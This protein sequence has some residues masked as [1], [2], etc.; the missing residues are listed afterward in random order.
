M[1]AQIKIFMLANEMFSSMF[2][3][4]WLI[5]CIFVIIQYNQ[6][7]KGKNQKVE[8]EKVMELTEKG[9]EAKLCPK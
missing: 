5:A 2:Y 7:T 6:Y 1:N 3:V 4:Y 8:Q 9:H